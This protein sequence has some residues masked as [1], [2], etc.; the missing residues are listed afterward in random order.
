MHKFNVNEHV[1]GFMSNF[2]LIIRNVWESEL[3]LC[4]LVSYFNHFPDL[5]KILMLSELLFA[6]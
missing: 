5:F 4:Y 2:M 6:L 1:I 3:S